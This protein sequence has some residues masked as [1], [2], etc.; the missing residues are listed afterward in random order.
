M[1]KVKS[2]LEPWKAFSFLPTAQVNSPTDF[3]E[4]S[5]RLI[6][7]SFCNFWFF[8]IGNP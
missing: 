8:L 3:A 7:L 4:A 5:G 1:Q 2:V 6:G